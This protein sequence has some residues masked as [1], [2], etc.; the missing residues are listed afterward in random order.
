MK[1]I[2]N[3]VFSDGLDILVNNDAVFVFGKIEDVTEE[4]LDKAFGVNV[5]GY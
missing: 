4:N 5:K 1:R 3:E 2:L